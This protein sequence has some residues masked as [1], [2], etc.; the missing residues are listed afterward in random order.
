VSTFDAF[1]GHAI[2]RPSAGASVLFSGPK[3]RSSSARD[4]VN[5]TTTSAHGFAPSFLPS[6]VAE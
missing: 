6:G 4:V 3:R 5:R 1:F 2:Q